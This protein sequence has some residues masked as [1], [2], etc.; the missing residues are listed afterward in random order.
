MM[1]V[2]RKVLL[3]LWFWL[4][5]SIST[6][7][8][9]IGYLIYKLVFSGNYAISDH[10]VIT[11]LIENVMAELILLWMTLPRFWIIN[12]RAVTLTAGKNA[13]DSNGPFLLAANHNSLI[14]T[15]F[16]ADLNYK[17]TYTYNVKWSMVPV[18]GW[19][20]V[21]AGYIGIDTSNPRAK[22]SVVPKVCSAIKNGYSVMV[23]PQGA[24]SRIPEASL[25]SINIKTGAFRVAIETG[26]QILPI[27]IEGSDKIVSRYGVVDS[28]SV[29]IV[30]GVPFSGSDV[31]SCRQLWVDDMN[32]IRT[33]IRS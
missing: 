21:L 23:Y 10:D 22:A 20:C 13:K 4:G 33:L 12:H 2:L 29:D 14:D 25:E 26:C 30:Y 8:T 7:L 11:Y 6:A 15:L 32:S 3:T 27:Y 1:N 9:G 16:I 17:K 24:R 28:G 19:L 31:N 18:F 5:V